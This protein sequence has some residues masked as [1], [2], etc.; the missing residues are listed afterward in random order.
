MIRWAALV[1][2]LPALAFAEGNRTV[3]PI[4]QTVLADHDIRYAIPVQVGDGPPVPALLDTGSTGLRVFRD[5]LAGGS[6]TDTGTASVYAY[7]SGE[8]LTGDIGTAGVAIG[9][10]TTD[11]QIPFE[12]V[13]NAACMNFQPDCGA[14]RVAPASYGIGGDGIAGAGFQ[15][16][17]GVSLIPDVAGVTQNPL[18]RIGSRQ[19]IIELPEP[20]QAGRG[21]LI[22]NPNEN[23]LAGFQMFPLRPLPGPGGTSG[24]ADFLSGCLNDQT[25][26][27]TICGPTVLD[28]GSPGILAYRQGATGG[29]LWAAGDSANLA[30]STGGNG[31]AAS[32]PF[33]TD[34]FPGTGLAAE[35]PNG[36]FSLVAGVLPFFAYDVL[37]DDA[38]GAIGLRPR[39]DAP[40][41]VAPPARETSPDIEV[42][43]MNAPANTPA[44]KSASRTQLPQVIYPEP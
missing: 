13:Q 6:F 8:K 28:T 4:T 5:A 21:S 10:E 20:D 16:I 9:T 34:G 36:P 42:I 44:A 14:A 1:C 11:A 25:A 31:T 7:G 29:P 37:Y 41:A 27:E 19:W 33:T 38:N 26:N 12:I 2:L 18:A 35:P 3:I 40:N 43:Q 32:I 15:A 22:L 24:W 23:D 17:I 39:A 30:F